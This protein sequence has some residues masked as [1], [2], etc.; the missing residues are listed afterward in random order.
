[1]YDLR[2]RFELNTTH[3]QAYLSQCAPRTG[4]AAVE[5]VACQVNCLQLQQPPEYGHHYSSY[6]QP[7]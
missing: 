6:K 1:M 4:K 2:S 5:P 7:G 3:E